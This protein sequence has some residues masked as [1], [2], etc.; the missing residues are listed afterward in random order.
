MLET[1]R[2]HSGH[3]VWLNEDFP[4]GA[5]G[6]EPACQ[7]PETWDT[8]IRSQGQEDPLEDGMA[9]HSSILT[10]R[11]PWTE[12]LVNYSPWDHSESDTA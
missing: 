5:S 9:T 12:E 4:G 2:R 6:I 11:T 3:N 1:R 10:W 8:R 7:G